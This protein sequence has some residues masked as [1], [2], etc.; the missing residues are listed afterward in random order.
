MR[1]MRLRSASA[2]LTFASMVGFAAADDAQERPPNILLILADDLGAY[3]LGCYGSTEV[4]TPNL[5]A[6]AAQGVRFTTCYATPQCTT[7]R[8]ELLT[9]KYGFRT[10]VYSNSGAREFDMAREA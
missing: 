9:G 10:G 5:D 4:R 2:V 8:I 3:D 7:S 6:L 1:R